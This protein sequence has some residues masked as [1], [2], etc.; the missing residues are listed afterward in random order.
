MTVDNDLDLRT[1]EVTVRAANDTEVVLELCCG[2]DHLPDS[3]FADI[4]LEFVLPWTKR[5]V[6]D[7]L[8]VTMTVSDG[9]RWNLHEIA[10][11]LSRLFGHPI[12]IQIGNVLRVESSSRLL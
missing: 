3:A 2:P 7:G 11:A 9:C 4:A 12:A 5:V 8:T 6:T 1:E 10:N